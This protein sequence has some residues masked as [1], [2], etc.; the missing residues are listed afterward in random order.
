MPRM[1]GLFQRSSQE[2]MEFSA[3]PYR[4]N[5]V[6]RLQVRYDSTLHR[7]SSQKVTRR[8]PVPLSVDEFLCSQFG[9]FVRTVVDQSHAMCVVKIRYLFLLVGVVTHSF[10]RAVGNIHHHRLH[11]VFS[12]LVLDLAVL[13]DTAAVVRLRRVLGYLRRTSQRRRFVFECLARSRA[14]QFGRSSTSITIRT[15]LWQ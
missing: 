10:L 5:V 12:C 2:A 11:E 3:L 15:L 14:R 9:L 6:S 4:S 7:F 13:L 1:V 8:N